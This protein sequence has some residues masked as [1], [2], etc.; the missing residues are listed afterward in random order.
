MHKYKEQTDDCQRGG[1][2]G[3]EGK[4]DK[5]VQIS[6]Y[7]INQGDIMYSIGYII[8]NIVKTLYGDRQLRLIL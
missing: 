4:I 3:K 5:E 8:S 6:S 1:I 7:K 2:W